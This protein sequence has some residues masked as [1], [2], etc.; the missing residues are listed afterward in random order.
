MPWCETCSR[1]LNPNTLEPDGSCPTCGRVV[2]EP[3]PADAAAGTGDTEVKK[4]APW[5]FKI[6][7]A[8][9]VVYLV[10]RFIQIGTWIF[11]WLVH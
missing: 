3:A 11:D 9:I 10:F 4:K 8:F 5:H 7:L 6:L 1:F 2:A